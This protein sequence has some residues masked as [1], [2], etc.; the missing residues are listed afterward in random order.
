MFKDKMVFISSV[1]NP[2]IDPNH[3]AGLSKELGVELSYLG[4]FIR[5]ILVRVHLQIRLTL[6]LALNGEKNID[7][8][9]RVI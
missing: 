8:A 2:F 9:S 6:I 1:F 4:P 5:G 7:I 3:L